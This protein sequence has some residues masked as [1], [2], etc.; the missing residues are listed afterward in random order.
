M[1]ARPLLW[2]GERA[3]FPLGTDSL[4]RDVACWHRLWGARV[5]LLV[6]LAAMLL[7]VAIGVAVGATAGY[8]RRPHG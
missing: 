7:G 8:F 4:G 2:P 3:E 6:G 5:S 1:V